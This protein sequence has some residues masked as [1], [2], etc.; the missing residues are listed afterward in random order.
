MSREQAARSEKQ[1]KVMG[2]PCIADWKNFC[3][4]ELDKSLTYG[5]TR[6]IFASIFELDNSWL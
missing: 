1:Y 3:Y 6:S 4:L 2:V 5:Q